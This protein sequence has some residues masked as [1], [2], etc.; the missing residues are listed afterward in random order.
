MRAIAEILRAKWLI[1]RAPISRWRHSV[2]L[3]EGDQKDR[4]IDLADA[5]IWAAHVERAALRL[6][7]ST[8]C[9]P[10]AIALSRILRA[11]LIPHRVVI[12][13]QVGTDHGEE[14]PDMLHAWLEVHGE[15]ILGDL[16]G[17]WHEILR[18]P[19]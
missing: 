4:P 3:D 16:P 6:P 14:N 19:A 13:H 17:E 1:A 12:A 11:S 7:L 10:L 18:M 9:L 2:G 5:K 8:K 15:I